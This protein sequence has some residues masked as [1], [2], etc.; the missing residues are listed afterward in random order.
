M[1]K[2][3]SLFMVKTDGLAGKANGPPFIVDSRPLGVIAHDAGEQ[4]RVERE[5]RPCVRACCC[6][7]W[8]HDT[9]VARWWLRAA[10]DKQANGALRAETDVGAASS[11]HR[12]HHTFQL[13]WEARCW[14][15]WKGQPSGCS[16]GGEGS[17]LGVRHGCRLKVSG[18]VGGIGLRL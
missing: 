6:F 12:Q 8:W 14:R 13:L 4:Q 11:D 9:R 16:W 7:T 17:S 3:A 10:G 2:T 15:D 18:L 5:E 1:T